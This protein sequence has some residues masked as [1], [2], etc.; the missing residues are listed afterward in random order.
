MKATIEIPDEL[1]GEVQARAALRGCSVR[2]VTI[3]LYRAWLLEGSHAGTAAEAE[4]V[5]DAADAWLASWEELG[6]EVARRAPDGGTTGQILKT[7]R[8]RC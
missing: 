2:D 3:S 7:D 4:P 5:A 1:Y 8:A 6:A